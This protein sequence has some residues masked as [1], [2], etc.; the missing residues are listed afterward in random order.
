MIK[1]FKE[2]IMRGNVIDM[3]VGIVIGGAFTAIVTSLVED[4]IMP[5][6]GLLT[7]GVDFKKLGVVLSTGPDGTPNV[8]AYGNLINAIV[9]FLLIALCVFLVIKGLNKLR[10]LAIK[11]KEEEEEE[12]EETEIDLLKEILT[13][14]QNEKK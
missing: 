6:L 5:L 8:L 9:S 1:E 14:L 7:S 2:F 11:E 10:N 3:A 13:T 12:P 4:I